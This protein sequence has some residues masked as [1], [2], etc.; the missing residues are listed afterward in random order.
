MTTPMGRP[1]GAEAGR[2]KWARWGLKHS[3]PN[4]SPD[5][6]Q[7]ILKLGVWLKAEILREARI[8]R[9]AAEKFV[10]RQSAIAKRRTPKLQRTADTTT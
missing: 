6:Y 9:E 4:Y 10:R 5:E 7:I 2:G 8:E 1:G 3:H